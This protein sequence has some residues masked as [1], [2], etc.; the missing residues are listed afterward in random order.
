MA[1]GDL[2]LY[3]LI[4]QR[5]GWLAQRQ[6][7]IANNVAN[8]NT[9]EFKPF[10]LKPFDYTHTARSISRPRMTL[11]NFSHITGS[12][13]AH[14]GPGEFRDTE[15]RRPHT[16]D[17]TLDGNAVNL[18]RELMKTSETS[19]QYTLVTRLYR[20]HIDMFKEVIGKKR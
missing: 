2:P 10:D 14:S 19:T 15:N 5:L 13:A 20:K 4:S 3:Q 18:E 1:N 6:R 9:P 16:Y 7:V 17:T 12:K 8:A 11:T